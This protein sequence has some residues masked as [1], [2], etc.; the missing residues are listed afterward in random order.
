MSS[1]G[2][3]G[4]W[5][6]KS[7]ATTPVSGLTMIVYLPSAWSGATV[8]RGTGGAATWSQLARL[9]PITNP[10]AGMPTTYVAYSTTYTG[11]WTYDSINRALVTV[12]RP[13]FTLT[14]TGSC[15]S[16]L[17]MY[18]RRTALVAGAQQTIDRSRSV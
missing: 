8:A 13:F 5:V 18:V 2:S 16:S 15:A 3:E 9:S 12:D 1:F 17:V 4:A 14:R 7:T 10:P 11:A 6:A